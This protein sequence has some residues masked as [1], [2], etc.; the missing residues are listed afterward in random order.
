M[1]FEWTLYGKSG[2]VPRVASC[3]ICKEFDHE[4]VLLVCD[5]CDGLYH[6]YC[7]D[8][9]ALPPEEEEWFCLDCSGGV[10]PPVTEKVLSANELL[11]QSLFPTKKENAE[12]EDLDNP[13]EMQKKEAAR[14]VLGI[15]HCGSTFCLT[16]LPG[17]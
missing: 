10:Q 3:S 15:C 14:Y 2:E 6:T 13:G 1:G 5:I 17:Y 4:D 12:G 8:L 7:V 11:P 9:E 16:V